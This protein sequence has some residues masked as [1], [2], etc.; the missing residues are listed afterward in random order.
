MMPLSAAQ[1]RALVEL[2]GILSPAPLVLIGASALSLQL[3]MRWRVTSDLDLTVA[4]G[5]DE[6]SRALERSN[7]WRHDESNELRWRWNEVVVDLIPAGREILEREELTLRSGRRLNLMGLRH[8]IE[9]ART[10]E[11][12]PGIGLKVAPVPVIALL[13]IVAFRDRPDRERDLHDLA[14]ILEDYPDPEDPRRFGNSVSDRGILY[15]DS[16]PHVLGAELASFVTPREQKAILA[17]LDEVI[18]EENGGRAQALILRYGPVSWRRD[19]DS[20]IR[21]LAVLRSSLTAQDEHTE[22]PHAPRTS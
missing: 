12:S 14:F 17:F 22:I 6:Y 7:H 19:P 8:A 21:K 11:L 5:M 4:S 20:L 3:D 15:E 13:K 18:H 2:E 9:R 16:G 10:L 1:V